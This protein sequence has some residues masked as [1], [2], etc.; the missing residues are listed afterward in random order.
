[1]NDTIEPFQLF[2]TESGNVAVDLS[3]GAYRK[4]FFLEYAEVF[5][6]ECGNGYDWI[7]LLKV[8]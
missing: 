4:D 6:D 2:C 8:S 3:V 7:C 5:E 1:M